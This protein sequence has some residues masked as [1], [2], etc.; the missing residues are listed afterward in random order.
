M[1]RQERAGGE[2]PRDGRAPRLGYPGPGSW[3]ASY[4]RPPRRGGVAVVVGVLIVLLAIGFFDY[5][6]FHAAGYT[7]GVWPGLHVSDYDEGAYIVS[8]QL[9]QK[10]HTIFGEVFSSQPAAFLG[11]LVLGL[12]VLGGSLG[13]A[14]VS[15]LVIAVFGALALIGVGWAAWASYGPAAGVAA[16]VALGLSPAM[17]LYS[18][19]IE[20]EI[21]M[22]GLSLLGVAA[23]HWY[24]RT[25]NRLLVVM[26]GLLLG[27]G[28]EMK[29]LAVVF[30]VPIALFVMGAS[31][32]RE[33]G[34]EGEWTTAEEAGSVEHLPLN[35]AVDLLLLALST[36]LP[37]VLVLGVF[38][39]R[40]QYD[41][42]IS[43]HFQASKVYPLDSGANL[44]A[45]RDMALWDPGLLIAAALG[46]VCAALR[47]RAVS[48]TIH[49]LWLLTTVLFLAR[50][51]PLIGH[52]LTVL[53]PPLAV[54]AGGLAGAVLAPR[55]LPAALILGV[56]G[57]AAWAATQV[58]PLPSLYATASATGVHRG[59][60]GPAPTVHLST[61]DRTTGLFLA[62]ASSRNGPLAPYT[63]HIEA[64]SRNIPA[65]VAAATSA[66]RG[67][68]LN[69]DTYRLLLRQCLSYWVTAH[70]QTWQRIVTDDLFVATQANRLV[71]PLLCDPSIVRARAGYLKEA[72]L[73]TTTDASRAKLVVIWRGVFSNR[74]LYPGFLPWLRAHYHLVNTGVPGAIVFV[75]GKP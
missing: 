61:L 9:L 71:P 15:H 47:R 64:N 28:L 5:E 34:A 52:Q 30:A 26:A 48:L 68:A 66:Q 10:G 54:A 45:I 59:A 43:F 70:T 12:K 58:A 41:Q 31:F 1:I 17:V 72:R 56:L 67:L 40:D 13:A 4:V 42:V 22:L 32:G 49:L 11:S 69:A 33:G 60:L 16:A 57:I 19:T 75:R 36:L 3:T 25:R 29:L 20:A 63:R 37:L 6:A 35:L 38:A 44:R 23:A 73:K 39:P 24:Y 74:Q 7:Y 51:H 14:V 53:F 62:V 27:L 50:Y 18:H 46:L 8:A 55:R 2:P 65:C 21:P